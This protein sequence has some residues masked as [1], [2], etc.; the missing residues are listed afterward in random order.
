MNCLPLAFFENVSSMVDRKTLQYL[1]NLSGN[2]S[3]IS[4]THNS[5]RLELKVNIFVDEWVIRGLSDPAAEVRKFEA[6]LRQRFTQQINATHSKLGCGE[7]FIHKN[8]LQG[9][10]K[11]DF[12][13]NGPISFNVE[14]LSQYCAEH[15]FDCH[16]P[17][18]FTVV[19][20]AK[21]EIPEHKSLQ[22]DCLT[23]FENTSYA[24]GFSL[25]EIHPLHVLENR[26]TPF[27]K[28]FC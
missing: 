9:S 6:I 7:Q 12:R 3:D 8:W 4:E 19:W 1:Q 20:T 16:R 18:R 5:R 2:W 27:G 24:G 13:F 26:K 22:L 25:G 23:K 10:L 14:D 17:D 28:S 21:H 15:N 11:S